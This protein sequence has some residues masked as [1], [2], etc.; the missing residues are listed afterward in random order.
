[1]LTLLI[2]CAIVFHN[3]PT[4][5]SLE[6]KL[7]DRLRSEIHSYASTVDLIKRAVVDDDGPLKN[8]T[9]FK[10]ANFVDDF[11]PRIAGSQNLEDAIDNLLVE[12]KS[13]K[14]DNVHGE[15]VTVPH[16]VR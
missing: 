2:I 5:F 8:A 6:C 4:I 10:L 7:N 16:W 1:M 3:A 15:N 9:W 12:F 11:G 14:L 13:A